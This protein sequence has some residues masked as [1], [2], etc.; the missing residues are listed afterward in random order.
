MVFVKSLEDFEIAAE[1]MY[2]ANPMACRYTMKYIHSKGQILL[3]MTDN[4]KV[5]IFFNYP[6]IIKLFLFG[7]V[8]NSRQRICQ[9]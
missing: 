2:M 3:K 6:I 8:F 1:N 7:S 9:I 5:T 4:A